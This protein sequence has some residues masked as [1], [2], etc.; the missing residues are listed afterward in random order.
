MGRKVGY[1]G[2]QRRVMGVSVPPGPNLVTG[3]EVDDAAGRSLINMIN[4]TIREPW[5]RRIVLWGSGGVIGGVIRGA[6]R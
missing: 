4:M 3:G 1:A 6:V 5:N 2:S